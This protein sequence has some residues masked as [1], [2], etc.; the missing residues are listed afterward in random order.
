[1][2][3]LSLH[4]A[5]VSLCANFSGSAGVLSSICVSVCGF[6]VL[7]NRVTIVLFSIIHIFLLRL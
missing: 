5:S 1:M 6:Q 7:F 3:L 2:F 4:N